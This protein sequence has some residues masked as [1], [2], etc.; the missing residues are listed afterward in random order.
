MKNEYDVKDSGLIFILSLFVPSLV[1]LFIMT[2]IQAVVPDIDKSVYSYIAVSVNQVGF[3]LI[4]FLY[5]KARKV[6]V[7][8]SANIKFNLNIKQILVI[9][10]IGLVCMYG[11]S[12][13]VNYMDWGVR[14]LGY[15]PDNSSFDFLSFSNF[16]MLIVDIVL[17]ALLPAICEELVFRGTIMNGLKKYGTTLMIVLSGLIFSIMHL[18][19]EQSIY[20]FVLGMVLASVSMITGSVVASMI[21]HF[22]NNALVLALNFISPTTE[23]VVWQPTCTWDHIAPFVFAIV[24]LA[25]IFGLLL[26]LKKCTKNVKYDIFSFKRKPKNAKMEQSSVIQE[27]KQIDGQENVNQAELSQNSIAINEQAQQQNDISQIKHKK[28]GL[29]DIIFIASVVC[30][31][32]LWVINVLPNFFK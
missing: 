4:F 20:Q 32:L 22:F 24:S 10:C 6:N 7:K 25:L 19:I 26:L 30:S 31:M 14:Q 12:S 28:L 15:N 9:I 16:G 17:V 21:L 11:F 23:S 2:I 8:Q 1:V 18:S 29:D 5:S 13:L 3:F 27:N